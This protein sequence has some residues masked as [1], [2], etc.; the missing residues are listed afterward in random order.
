M[1]RKRKFVERR[2]MN[3]KRTGLLEQLSYNGRVPRDE[4]ATETNSIVRTEFK[5]WAPKETIHKFLRSMGVLP[6]P[7]VD[8]D[9]YSFQPPLLRI[10]YELFFFFLFLSVP[11]TFDDS[12]NIISLLSRSVVVLLERN[13]FTGRERGVRKVTVVP[14]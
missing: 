8:L 13:V 5:A 2:R 1:R 6:L 14:R 9:I 10:F 4:Q 11:P 7:I 12:S 3:N